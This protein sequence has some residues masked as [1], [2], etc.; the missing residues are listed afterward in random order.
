MSRRLPSTPKAMTAEEQRALVPP[1][2][3]P[4]MDSWLRI[5]QQTNALCQ[6]QVERNKE[7]I[8]QLYGPWLRVGRKQ[9]YFCI[10][11]FLI[12]FFLPIDIPW[13]GLVDLHG[14]N[15]PLFRCSALL[16]RHASKT[17]AA[18]SCAANTTHFFTIRPK[19][20]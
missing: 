3:Q 10:E 2:L 6:D 20:R 14:H 15:F 5:H 16:D 1:E 12:L 7:W 9:C 4:Y 8:Q 11:S 19:L 17:I 18:T 13:H